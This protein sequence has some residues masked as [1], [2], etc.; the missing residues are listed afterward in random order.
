[1]TGGLVGYMNRECGSLPY[2]MDAGMVSN[3]EISRRDIADGILSIPNF[4]VP[5]AD[6]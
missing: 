2:Q 3:G 4:T 6:G 1:M 5:T